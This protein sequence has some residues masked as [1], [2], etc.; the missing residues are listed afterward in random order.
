MKVETLHSTCSFA[1]ETRGESWI[2]RLSGL[3]RS[4]FKLIEQK[5]H[6]HFFFKKLVGEKIVVK[7][8]AEFLRCVFIHGNRTKYSILRS[9]L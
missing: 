8:Q 9:A 3:T 7:V 5:M 2:T 1:C 4:L 6:A